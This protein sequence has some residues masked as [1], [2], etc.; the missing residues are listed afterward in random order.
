VWRECPRTTR[1]SVGS[2]SASFGASRSIQWNRNNCATQTGNNSTALCSITAGEPASRYWKISV[3]LSPEFEVFTN[4]DGPSCGFEFVEGEIYLVEVYRNNLDQRWKVS[5]CSAPR[6]ASAAPDE[7][8]AL[9]AWKVGLQ[10]RVRIF[11]DVLSPDG[12]Q[13][14]AGIK[15]SLLGGPQPL[16]SISDSREKFEFQNLAAG[17]YHSYG[18]LRLHDRA[19]SI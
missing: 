16:E 13:S 5:S 1:S 8:N 3:T 17:N 2:L 4:L 9:R 14:P 15:L 19:R 6:L 7:V 11:G 18:L 12:R 10:P